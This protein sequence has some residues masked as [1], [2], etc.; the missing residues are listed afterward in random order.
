[1]AGLRSTD[2]EEVLR[3]DPDGRSFSVYLFREGRRACVESLNRPADHMVAR[4]LLTNRVAVNPLQAAD[5]SFD[6]KQ[7]LQ[8]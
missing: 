8:P 2:C 6:L 7:L 1:M 5:T 4:R 3:G